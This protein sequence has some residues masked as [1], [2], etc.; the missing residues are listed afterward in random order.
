MPDQEPLTG[1]RYD[2]AIARLAAALEGRLH[3]RRLSSSDLA[4]YTGSR[5]IDGWR[6][7][8]QFPDGDRDLDLLI[9]KDLPFSAPVVALSD[10]LAS[11]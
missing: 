9:D 6:V 2:D 4:R 10:H 8:A 11:R 1:G 3:A 7:K 5:F